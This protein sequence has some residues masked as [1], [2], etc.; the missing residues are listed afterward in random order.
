MPVIRSLWVLLAALLNGFPV[1]YCLAM[2]NNLD[3]RNPMMAKHLAWQ[4]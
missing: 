2:W 4:K 3:L 1:L